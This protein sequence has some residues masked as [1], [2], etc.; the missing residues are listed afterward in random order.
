MRAL[1]VYESMFGNTHEVANCIADG[2]RPVYDVSMVRVGDATDEMVEA[3]DLVIVGGPTHAH[4]LSG[5][6]RASVTGLLL[7]RRPSADTATN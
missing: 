6:R 3:A 5:P 7:M 1:I 2:L 4:G